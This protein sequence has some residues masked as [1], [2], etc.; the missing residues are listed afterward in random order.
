[1]NRVEPTSS[2]GIIGRGLAGLSLARALARKGYSDITIYGEKSV[3]GSATRAAVGVVTVKGWNEPRQPLFRAKYEGHKTLPRWIAGL[4]KDTGRSVRQIWGDIYEPFRDEDQYLWIRERVYHRD[5]HGALAVSVS[6]TPPLP[7]SLQAVGAFQYWQDGWVDPVDLVEALE[8]S[9]TRYRTK[10]MDINCHHLAWEPDA[11][12]RVMGIDGIL[13]KHD[14]VVLAAGIFSNGI[15]ARSELDLP[16]LTPVSGVTLQVAADA[17]T[18]YAVIFG[19]MAAAVAGGQMRF[20]STSNTSGI[21]VETDGIYDRTKSQQAAYLIDF[22][23]DLGLYR[24]EPDAVGGIRARS[25]DRQ[26]VV[27]FTK[28][29]GRGRLGLFTG[30]YKS[31]IQL[32]HFLA[33]SLA[34]AWSFGTNSELL[35]LFSPRRF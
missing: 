17:M 14:E 6:Q 23:K 21:T 7:A 9:A 11:K 34:D 1:M 28:I 26:P 3:P 15:A 31:G 19:K 33:E 30:L 10:I 32:S 18:E 27:G 29:P 2:I 35:N 20:G 4:E 8:M 25:K 13:G 5:F 12:I 24:G 22:I 16:S